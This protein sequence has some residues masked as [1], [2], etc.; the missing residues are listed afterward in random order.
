MIKIK[1]DFSETMQIWGQWKYLFKVVNV[2]QT[3]NL[4]FS[5]Q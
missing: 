2:K 3:V 1:L 5:N 4:E